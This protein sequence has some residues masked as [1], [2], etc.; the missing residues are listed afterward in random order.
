MSANESDDEDIDALI[1]RFARSHIIWVDDKP[2]PLSIPQPAAPLQTSQHRANNGVATPI[3]RSAGNMVVETNSPLINTSVESIYE[4]NYSEEVSQSDTVPGTSQVPDLNDA[5]LSSW[6]NLLQNTNDSN[7]INKSFD[8]PKNVSVPQNET[9]YAHLSDPA[10]TITSTFHTNISSNELSVFSSTF[11]SGMNQPDS[12][13]SMG[14]GDHQPSWQQGQPQTSFDTIIPQR[15]DSDPTY[16]LAD[17]PALTSD[18]QQFP[19][20]YS[21]VSAYS[22]ANDHAMNEDQ[23]HTRLPS[24]IVFGG[25]EDYSVEEP[26]V[27]ASPSEEADPRVTI[28]QI[29]GLSKDLIEAIRAMSELGGI[30]DIKPG[31]T[32][33]PFTPIIRVWKIQPLRPYQVSH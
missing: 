7:Y 33:I 32:S 13:A 11:L 9:N 15:Y 27:Y 23:S 5:A 20:H 12:D 18:N 21:Q 25:L 8:D 19:T 6:S 28:G 17:T 10:N 30:D 16:Y 2:D 3:D 26:T 31:S 24:S 14:F 1:K 22:G 4:L 29:S